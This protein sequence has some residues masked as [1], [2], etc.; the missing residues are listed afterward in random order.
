MHLNLQ[1]LRTT[2]AAFVFG[3]FSSAVLAATPDEIILPIQT[4]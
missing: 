2:A 3:F 4:Q 1:T